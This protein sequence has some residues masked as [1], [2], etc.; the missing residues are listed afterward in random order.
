MYT[1]E[2]LK[3]A[4]RETMESDSRKHAQNMADRICGL[5]AGKFKISEAQFKDEIQKAWLAGEL[6][7]AE[8]ILRCIEMDPELDSRDLIRGELHLYIMENLRVLRKHAP[9]GYVGVEELIDG[10]FAT[11]CTRQ[12]SQATLS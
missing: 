10:R 8:R 2:D 11:P 9:V 4:C 6:S 12:A 1:I 5:R 3:T 7:A